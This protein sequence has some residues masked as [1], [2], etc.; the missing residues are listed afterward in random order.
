MECQNGRHED[1]GIKQ[2]WVQISYQPLETKLTESN[3]LSLNHKKKIEIVCGY[4]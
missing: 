1:S 3:F 4:M 2:I